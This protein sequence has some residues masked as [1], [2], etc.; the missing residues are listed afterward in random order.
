MLPMDK[1]GGCV[2][3]PFLPVC[4]HDYKRLK[5]GVDKPSCI[6]ERHARNDKLGSKVV[7]LKPE[8]LLSNFI[9]MNHRRVVCT[10]IYRGI[11]THLVLQQD[12]MEGQSNC[13][14]CRNLNFLVEDIL[15]DMQDSQPN[16]ALCMILSITLQKYDFVL[17]RSSV[18]RPHHNVVIEQQLTVS[19]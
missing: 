19:Y 12:I 8:F 14:R 5:R 15:R 17:N 11:L 16:I 18:R 2:S 6:Q 4:A 10:T 7:Y 13:N 1:A 9:D 3:V